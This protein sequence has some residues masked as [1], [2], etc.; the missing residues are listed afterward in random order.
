MCVAHKVC[1][2]LVW[3]GAINWGLIGFFKFNL[4][5]AIFGGWPSFERIV[6]ALVGLAAI[7]MLFACKCKHCGM[8]E[9]KKM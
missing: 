9:A 3:I 8:P 7:L 6:Y 2:A 5:N 1:G 4:V